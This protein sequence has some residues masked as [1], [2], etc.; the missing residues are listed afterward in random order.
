MPLTVIPSVRKRAPP[1]RHGPQT[2]EEKTE[3]IHTFRV[4]DPLRPRKELPSRAAALLRTGTAVPERVAGEG[5][6][7]NRVRDGRRTLGG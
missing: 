7:T 1:S 6:P 4:R 3:A 5:H 2:A